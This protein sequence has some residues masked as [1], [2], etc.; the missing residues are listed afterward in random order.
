LQR[1]KF[2]DIGRP[3]DMPAIKN[4]FIVFSSSMRRRDLYHKH[5]GNYVLC[6]PPKSRGCATWFVVDEQWAQ[7]QC[8]FIRV[9]TANR[10]LR[11]KLREE[12]DRFSFCQRSPLHNLSSSSGNRV[13]DR[14]GLSV[15]L[16]NTQIAGTNFKPDAGPLAKASTYCL[17]I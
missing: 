1:M 17:P 11:S 8:A 10:R 14:P 3:V 7:D 4:V 13:I 5:G 6:N 9:P 15:S 12:A 16:H 2:D